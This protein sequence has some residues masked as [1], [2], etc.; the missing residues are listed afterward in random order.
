MNHLVA[1]FA[2][3]RLRGALALAASVLPLLAAPAARAADWPQWRGPNRD[4]VSKETGLLQEWPEDG[5]PLAWKATGLGTGH[6]SVSVAGGRIYTMGDGPNGSYVRALDEKTGKL[7]WSTQLG[8]AGGGEDRDPN[9]TGT[10][11]TPTVDGDRLYVLGQYGELACLTTDGKQVWEVD[12][13]KD[14]G[15]TIQTWGYSESPLVD[16]EKVICTPGG[17]KGTILALD[18]KTGKPV[19]Q[20]KEWTDKVH[21]SSPIVATIG[22]VRQYVQQT[23]KSVAGVAAE[24]GRLLWK[25]DRPQG[26]VAVIPTPVEKDGLVYV[27]AGYGAGCHLFKVSPPPSTDGKFTVEQVYA[28][29]EM[30]NHH[31]GVILLGEHLYGSD[32][33][34]VLKCIDF[35]TGKVAWKDRSVGK[36]SILIA[37]GR[38][39]LRSEQSP[40]EVAL[41]EATPKRYEEISTFTPPDASGKSTWPHPVIANGKLYLRDQDVLLCY[42]VKAK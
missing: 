30:K 27:S 25:A 35:K 34:G 8:K 33:P 18:K 19:W 40:G 37:D 7:L 29:T 38:L 22:G 11:C 3:V 4:G 9:R 21:Y 2:P 31:G 13:V 6:S 15:G 10:R 28:N 26:R 41:V 24:D 16:G 23:E 5:P 17:A 39:Y 20:S 32:D 1:R 14:F 12:L 42:D 36:G